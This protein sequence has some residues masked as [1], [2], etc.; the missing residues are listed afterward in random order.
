MTVTV[1]KLEGIILKIQSL[2]LRVKKI[3]ASASKTECVD[4]QH[5]TAG[6]AIAKGRTRWGK[7]Q[8]SPSF[9][10]RVSCLPLLAGKRIT[11]FSIKSWERE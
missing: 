2:T 7:D 4:I 10:N 11:Q 1:T 9:Q 3:S 8:C 6:F 5:Y